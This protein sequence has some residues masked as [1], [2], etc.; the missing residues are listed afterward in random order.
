MDNFCLGGLVGN[1]VYL[2]HRADSYVQTWSLGVG[3]WVFSSLLVVRLAIPAARLTPL[4]IEKH[5]G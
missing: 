1:R 5:L 3:N 2:P 4:A